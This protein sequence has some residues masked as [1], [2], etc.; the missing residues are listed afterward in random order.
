MTF[1]FPLMLGCLVL[2]GIPVLVHIIM[3]QKPRHLLFP[4][5]RFLLQRHQT[6]QRKLRL[7]HIL[8]LTLRILL[9]AGICLAL[10]RPKVFNERLNLSSDQPVAAVILLD[11]SASMQYRIKD[12]TRLDVAKRRAQELLNELPEG[13]RVAILDTAEP[14]GDWLPTLSLAR[15]RLADRVLRPAN[16]PITSRLAE[17]YQLLNDLNTEPGQSSESMPRFL[18]VFS[19]RTQE[20]W[21]ADR[22]KDLR[23]VRERLAGTVREL[24][25]DVGAEDPVDVALGG[26]D[27]PRQVVPVGDV[28]ILR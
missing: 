22:L 20:C 23:Q 13:S 3:R 5:F 14:G 21:D 19:D 25:V 28:A 1:V 16:G 18:Y 15:D 2:A 27:L 8:L 7:R 4:A 9:I 10:A 11:T 12:E 26:V 17:A 24:F 6:N